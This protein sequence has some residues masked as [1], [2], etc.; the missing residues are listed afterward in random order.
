MIVEFDVTLPD[1]LIERGRVLAA[2]CGMNLEE[3]IV[4]HMRAVV[5]EADMR[6]AETRA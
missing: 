1:E 2:S 3:M 6:E 4:E 5:A